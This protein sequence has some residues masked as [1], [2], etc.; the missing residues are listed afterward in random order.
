MGVSF[1]GKIRNGVKQICHGG[2][3]VAAGIW[4]SK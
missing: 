3:N 1:G 4:S 2:I